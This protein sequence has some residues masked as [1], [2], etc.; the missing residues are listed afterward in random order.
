MG[1]QTVNANRSTMGLRSIASLVE[2]V[3]RPA[4]FEFVVENRRHLTSCGVKGLP[5]E[6][7]AALEISIRLNLV[8]RAA[9]M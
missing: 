7:P 3:L 4:I 9:S 5:K 8:D 2:T 1:Q 6:T